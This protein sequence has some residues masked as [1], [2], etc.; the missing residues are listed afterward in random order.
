MSLSITNTANGKVESFAPLSENVHIVELYKI[1]NDNGKD[2]TGFSALINHITSMENF[3]KQAEDNIA[4]IKIQLETIK[5][6]QDRPIKHILQKAV[7]SLETK[8][9]EIKGLIAD[10][11]AVFIERCKNIVSD[12]KEK[13]ISTLDQLAT[14][15]NIRNNL[16]S[17]E[18]HIEASI[19]K[20]NKSLAKIESFSK[21]YYDTGRHMKNM[22]RILTGNKPID[23]VKESGKLGKAISA[24]YLALKSCMK[25]MQKVV[26]KTLSKLTQLEQGAAQK[27]GQVKGKKPSIIDM[28]NI[29]KELV[30]QREHEKTQPQRALKSKGMEI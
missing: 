11:K 22:I 28:L 6:I 13:G 8:V 7:K 3:V 20:C 19:K 30:Q 24:P 15:F 5:E 25:N 2:T 14:L 29:N 16:E 17:I 21:E 26:D 27:S 4:N 10:L 1:L 23:I 9:S 18:V 12:F